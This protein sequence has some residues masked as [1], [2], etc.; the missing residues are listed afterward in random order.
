VQ[1][2]G[3]D[4]DLFD[5]PISYKVV[6]GSAESA[7]PL[8]SGRKSA[9]VSLVNLDRSDV[10]RFDGLYVG[11]YRGNATIPGLGGQKINGTV[12]FRVIGGQITVEEPGGGSGS[13]SA[14]G[15]AGFST[16]GGVV[17]GA[18]YSGVFRGQRGTRNV[19]VSGNWSFLQDGISANGS[20]MANRMI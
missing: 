5:G 16:T 11:S 3:I 19:S 17:N 14:N 2:L 20:W 1:V 6:T 15:S 8:Y 18:A 12:R 13:L 4:D 10:A 9:D 7:D